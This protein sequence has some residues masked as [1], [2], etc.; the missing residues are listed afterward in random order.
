MKHKA[1]LDDVVGI[2]VEFE[3]GRLLRAEGEHGRSAKV[4]A[5]A[6]RAAEQLGWHGGAATGWYQAGLSARAAGNAAL[7]RGSWDSWMKHERA[8]GN[9]VGEAAALGNLGVVAQEE[10]AYEEATEFQRRG[11]E[12]LV[13]EGDRAGQARAQINIGG[14]ATLTGDYGRARQALTG[15]RDLYKVLN[16]ARGEATA[17]TNLG[18][19]KE[20]RGHFPEALT[21]HRASLELMSK[22]EYAAAAAAARVNVGAVLLRLGETPE[23]LIELRRA[24][25]TYRRLGDRVGRARSLGALGNAYLDLGE[26][27][28]AL[29]SHERSLRLM[30]ENRDGLGEANALGNIGAVHERRGDYAAALRMFQ[31]ALERLQALQ[32]PAGEATSLLNIGVVYD[33]LGQTEEARDTYGRALAILETIGDDAGA[34]AA[35]ANLGRIHLRQ[36]QLE[37][38]HD[39]MTRAVALAKRVGDPR[40]RARA[41]INLAGL[42]LRRE[43]WDDARVHLD[44]ALA[45]SR[46]SGDHLGEALALGSLAALERLR[47]TP[48][49]ARARLE[50]SLEVAR[51]GNARP[52]IV[53]RLWE[54]AALAL[55][56]GDARTAVRQ[57]REAA[58][59]LPLLVRGQDEARAA[60]GRAEWVGL[61]Q[62]GLR[63]S[64]A[65]GDLE[66]AAWFIEAG[67]A[68]ALLESLGGRDS[69]RTRLVPQALREQEA[70]AR[71]AEDRAARVQRKAYASRAGLR[72]LRSARRALNTARQ[73]LREVI[74]R[75]QRE[76]KASADVLY[77]Q[78]KRLSE[79][80]AALEPGDVLVLYA[81][82]DPDS[83]ALVVRKSGVVARKLPGHDA[84][85]AACTSMLLPGEPYVDPKAAV[86]LRELAFDPL[87]LKETDTRVLVAPDGPLAL[88]PLS[89][90]L[91]GR[92]LAFVPS[93]TTYVLLR[94]QR[95]LRGT[96]VLG[97]GDPVYKG[98]VP[99]LA[100]LPG[101]REEVQRVADVVRL[102]PQAHEAALVE[103]LGTRRRWRAVHF[104][105]HGLVDATNPMM[106]ALALSAGPGSDGLLTVS[107]LLR[108]EAP[109]D[110]VALSA[111]NTGRGKVVR[112]E[113]ILG[114]VRAF[115]FAGAPR[116]LVSQWKVDDAATSAFMQKLYE[117]W[118]RAR[119]VAGRVVG[120]S[121]SQG[122]GVRPAPMEA[123]AV[124]GALGPVGIARC[125]QDEPLG[126]LTGV[127]G[128]TRAHCRCGGHGC[129]G[130]CPPVRGSRSMEGG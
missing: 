79:I 112:G 13:A 57:A 71:V 24:D 126:G 124:L 34:A 17:L 93:G 62:T 85:A 54:L 11:L 91:P 49:R 92:N 117:H 15:A 87:G 122:A 65:L 103:A 66:E 5:D 72:K 50:E 27:P 64:L 84:I 114:F 89:L 97:F 123:P 100:S 14:L 95:G 29:S 25:A 60:S 52:L 82:D 80:Q 125:R 19:L 106:S 67:R 110:F 33:A 74:E 113:G 26:I 31:S 98:Y 21:L 53:R 115:M 45:L 35:V 83:V 76:A 58:E 127:A 78:P 12:L 108:I 129:T 128:R 59:E 40:T 94:E 88:V 30:R 119:R 116:V 90:L 99:R 10:G 41:R 96:D 44:Q 130:L 107:D 77:P 81:L 104:A 121:S 9:R 20:S 51:Q 43:Q 22:P 75:V 55:D 109:A 1:A 28:R 37:E 3:R 39:A 36:G 102:G 38:A 111:C 61:F 48:E 68:G 16:D 18:L 32:H 46:R 120:S 101:T 69:L 2:Q 70:A 73:A 42:H 47:G 4:L 118:N 6:A 8:R 86:H 105:C 23:A 56:G 7:T 63:A